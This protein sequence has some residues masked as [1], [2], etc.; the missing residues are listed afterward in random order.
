MW[1]GLTRGLQLRQEN[2]RADEA[3]GLDRS[4]LG[5]LQQ[6]LAE[7]QVQRGRENQW[8]EED[9]RTKAEQTGREQYRQALAQA[10][11]EVETF[12]RIAPQTQALLPGKPTGLKNPDGSQTW[13]D[14]TGQSFPIAR[15]AAARFGGWAEQEARVRQTEDATNRANAILAEQQRE[16]REGRYARDM[17][18]SRDATA[19]AQGLLGAGLVM[20]QLSVYGDRPGMIEDP[21]HAQQAPAGRRR[22]AAAEQPAGMGLMPQAAQ[23]PGGARSSARGP[24]AGDVLEAMKMQDAIVLEADARLKEI[25]TRARALTQQRADYGMGNAREKAAIDAELAALAAEAEPL[26]AERA[27]AREA[28]DAYRKRQREM[29]TPER[30]LLPLPVIAMGI[31][32]P[33]E[34][35][36]AEQAPARAPLTLD[37]A[38]ATLA[39]ADDEA[40]ALGKQEVGQATAGRDMTVDQR[41]GRGEGLLQINSARDLVNPRKVGIAAVLAPLARK[42]LDWGKKL[43]GTAF[44]QILNQLPAAIDENR[45]RVWFN[46]THGTDIKPEDMAE[47]LPQIEATL[48]AEAQQAEQAKRSMRGARGLVGAFPIR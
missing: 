20:P 8:T 38:R 48:E 32:E 35:T 12:G 7:R 9:R 43:S 10:M 40:V 1:A 23:E 44:G 31:G 41:Y 26:T 39:S 2:R 19:S 6:D 30:G 4:R 37:A 25:E 13:T 34:R 15:E 45:L 18:A 14:Q 21:Q 27:R 17:G 33:P 28:R 36:A 29:L 42:L 11:Q 46:T 24:G 3:L 5:L 47:M 16:T 22:A